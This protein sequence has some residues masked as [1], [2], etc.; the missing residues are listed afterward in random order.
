M[1]LDQQPAHVGEEESSTR[2]VGIGVALGVF[3]MY[4]VIPCP[5]VDGPLIGDARA[6]HEERTDGPMRLVRSM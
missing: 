3:V 2:V 6:E 4:A 1:F 5:V